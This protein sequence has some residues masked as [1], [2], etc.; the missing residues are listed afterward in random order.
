MSDLQGRGFAQS[1]N[2]ITDPSWLISTISIQL[3]L[4]LELEIETSNIFRIII[5]LSLMKA[6]MW[7]TWELPQGYR[8]NISRWDRVDN[9]HILSLPCSKH[10]QLS[11]KFWSL[12]ILITLC[13]F[14]KNTFAIYNSK[15]LRADHLFGE[16]CL[17]VYLS[18]VSTVLMPQL[19]VIQDL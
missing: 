8:A 18:F 9:P 16:C 6:E 3:L 4:N 7:A 1:S 2:D 13:S 19:V 11:A 15:L 17:K 5:F 12:S 10:V 14:E